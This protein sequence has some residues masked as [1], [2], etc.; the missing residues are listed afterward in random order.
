MKS[1]RATFHATEA[2]LVGATKARELFL[3]KR[4]YFWSFV[5][6]K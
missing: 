3:K 6:Y 5:Y 2:L 1:Y 4:A